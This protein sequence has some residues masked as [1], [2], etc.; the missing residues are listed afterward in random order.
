[1]GKSRNYQDDLIASLKNHEEAVA[2]LNAAFEE[3]LKGD[4]ESQE[5]LLIAFR[6]VAQAQGG[7]AEIAK[8]AHIGRESLYKTLSLK[9][10]PEW[11]TLVALVRAMGLQ[12]RFV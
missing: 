3:S 8:K 11:R 4:A 7:V 5:L 10:N 9:G 1:M 12:L 2:Y 6:N